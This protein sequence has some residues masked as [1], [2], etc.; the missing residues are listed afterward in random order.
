MSYIRFSSRQQAHY[1]FVYCRITALLRW[2]NTKRTRFSYNCPFNIVIFHLM[3]DWTMNA[4]SKYWISY[5]CTQ[6]E[7]L[8]AARKIAENCV[9]FVQAVDRI[10][11][12]TIMSCQSGQRLKFPRGYHRT[13]CRTVH[14]HSAHFLLSVSLI[15][16]YYKHMYL[17]RCLT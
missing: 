11:S 6:I 3:E 17:S 10:G 9:I 14:Y 15:S 13:A 4:K 12:V 8:C 2:W 16:P 1:N 7:R 5:L